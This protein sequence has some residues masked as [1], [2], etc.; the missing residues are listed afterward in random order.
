MNLTCIGVKKLFLGNIFL[1]GVFKKI[2]QKTKTIVSILILSCLLQRVPRVSYF[3]RAYHTECAYLTACAARLFL[4][5]SA[6]NLFL[7]LTSRKI[8]SFILSSR[9]IL[10]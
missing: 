9:K 1:L 4:V 2:K 5:C 10:S 6:T 3:A 7:P 8:L